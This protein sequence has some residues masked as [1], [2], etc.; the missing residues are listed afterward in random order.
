MNTEVYLEGN[1]LYRFDFLNTH[2]NKT[3]RSCK[4]LHN[5]SFL[6]HT[7]LINIFRFSLVSFRKYLLTVPNYKFGKGMHLI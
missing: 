2:T 4:S 1:P 3:F 5:T 7:Q 6:I